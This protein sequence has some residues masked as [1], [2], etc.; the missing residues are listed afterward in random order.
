[1]KDNQRSTFSGKLGSVLSMMTKGTNKA[2]EYEWRLWKVDLKS[3]D[4]GK[5]LAS[6]DPVRIHI[7]DKADRTTGTFDELMR[8]AQSKGIDIEEMDESDL[9]FDIEAEV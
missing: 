4:I 7:G 5:I 3:S 9:A 6:I 1:M 8:V 2:L